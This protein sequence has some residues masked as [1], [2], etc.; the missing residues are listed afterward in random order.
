MGFN[1]VK[2]TGT[3]WD[4]EASTT[5][6]GSSLI[7]SNNNGDIY[8]AAIGSSGNFAGSITDDVLLEKSRFR[9]FS[10]GKVLVG[11][12][13]SQNVTACV[14][15]SPYTLFVKGGIRTEEVM[16]ETG[17]CDY[18]FSPSYHLLTLEEVKTHI[19]EKGYLHNTPSA[20]E[21]AENG[22]KLGE[23]SLQHQKK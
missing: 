2:G 14:L 19:V 16:V 17:W 7:F 22:N 6:N 10:N 9:I 3:N 5:K 8:F 23:T 20:D 1:L 13:P 18:V 11:S 15:S 12:P 4:Y 21:I